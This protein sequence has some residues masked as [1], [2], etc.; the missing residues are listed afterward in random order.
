[1]NRQTQRR[2]KRNPLIRFV[3]SVL[4]LLRVLFRPA[5]KNVRE[6]PIETALEIERLRLQEERDREL[7]EQYITVGELLERVQWQ[8]SEPKPAVTSAS[9]PDAQIYD[10]SLN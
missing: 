9:Q 3:R 2:L 8:F 7:A 4:R 1:M 10:V 6:I 5:S